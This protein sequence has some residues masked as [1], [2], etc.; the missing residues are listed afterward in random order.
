M[1][2]SPAVCLHADILG[3]SDTTVTKHRKQALRHYQSMQDETEG[4]RSSYET[5]LM[6]PQ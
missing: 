1:Q 5:D 6:I 3:A 4:Q 2:L